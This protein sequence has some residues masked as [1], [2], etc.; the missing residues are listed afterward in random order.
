[1]HQQ[2]LGNIDFGDVDFM[3]K[4]AAK[5]DKIKTEFVLKNVDFERAPGNVVLVNANDEC[6][7]LCAGN[8]WINA[9]NAVKSQYHTMPANRMEMRKSVGGNIMSNIENTKNDKFTANLHGF[10]V[11]ELKERLTQQEIYAWE[12]FGLDIDTN[13]GIRYIELEK[14]IPGIKFEDYDRVFKFIAANLPKFGT[15]EDATRKTHD[16]VPH[17]F[18]KYGKHIC[19]KIYDKAYELEQAHNIH[20]G[21]TEYLRTEIVLQDKRT[22]L[23]QLGIYN[24]DG[25]T[26]DQVQKYYNNFITKFIVDPYMQGKTERLTKAAQIMLEEYNKDEGKKLWARNSLDKFLIYENKYSPIIL[27]QQELSEALKI[28]FIIAGLKTKGDNLKHVRDNIKRGFMSQVNNKEQFE[29]FKHNDSEKL[30]Y[31]IEQLIYEDN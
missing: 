6:N 13:A 18:V 8:T 11:N 3:G 28:F 21:N 27:D 31:L 9:I 30:Q 12:E 1:M 20:V 4:T 23:S 17:G 24:V 22:I 7:N 16:G 14:T 29:V 10:T 26:E 25:V 2:L 5:I 19:F 15:D